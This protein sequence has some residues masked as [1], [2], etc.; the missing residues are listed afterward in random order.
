MNYSQLDKLFDRLWPICRS[1]TGPGI[2]ESL[3]ILSEYVPFNI[4]E[5]PTGTKVFDWVVP[6]EWELIRATLKTE[7][8]ELILDT[9]INN[10]HILNFSEPFSGIISFDEL[11][12]HL[13]SDPNLPEA[14]PYVTSYYASRWGLC[15]SDEQKKKLRTDIN[16]IVDIKT[17]KFDGNLRYGDYL[18]KGKTEETILLTSYLCH[19]SLA[20]NEISG[21]LALVSIFKKLE[22]IKNLKFSYRFIILPETIGSISFLANTPSTELAKI[23]SGLVLTCLGGPSNTVSFKHSRRHWLGEESLIDDVVDKLCNNEE[24]SFVCRDFTP[25]GGS[26]ERQF[27]SPSVNMAM[28]Q[29]ARTVYGQYDEYHTSLDNKDFMDI[30]SVMNSVEK[31]L[32]FLKFYELEK[33]HLIPTIKGG[34]P[35]L[36]KRNLYP[37]VN[38]SFTRKMSSDGKFDGREQLDSILNVI[39]FVDGKRRLSEIADKLNIPYR[40]IVPIVEELI[41]KGVFSCE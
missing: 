15:I 1:I 36:S 2:S 7:D 13:Y 19:P 5:I 30:S 17:R 31:I 3:S 14:I 27:C 32:F 24:N 39:S 34:E 12:K 38:S 11:D 37:S 33:S 10:I 16:Y 20:N 29:A 6:Q 23:T 41:E 26:D 8:G 9:D 35:M 21:P 25:T 4:K 28:I 40:K 22:K 18:L